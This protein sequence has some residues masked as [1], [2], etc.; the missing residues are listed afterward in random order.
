[1]LFA[2]ELTLSLV[3]IDGAVGRALHPGARNECLCCLFE[4]VVNEVRQHDL[5]HLAVAH[6]LPSPK[7][8]LSNSKASLAS[9]LTDPTQMHKYHRLKTTQFS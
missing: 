2:E 6:L 3:D 8:H 5:A 1:M 4:A 7:T 9:A